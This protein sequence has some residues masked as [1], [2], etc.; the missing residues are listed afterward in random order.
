MSTR[1]KD[2]DNRLRGKRVCIVG[3]AMSP[4]DYTE[5][6]FHYD[7]VVL[8][9]WAIKS[10]S[11]ICSNREKANFPLTFFSYHYGTPFHRDQFPE[12]LMANMTLAL[13]EHDKP[14]VPAEKLELG[15]YMQFTACNILP[16]MLYR[17]LLTTNSH[18]RNRSMLNESNCLYSS[19][20]TT[21]LALHYLYH[22]G[23]LEV[24]AVGMHDV[25]G[26]QAQTYDTRL[27]ATNAPVPAS[28]Y[29]QAQSDFSLATGMK[30]Y[31]IEKA[32]VRTDL[33]A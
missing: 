30:I 13:Q 17:Q 33:M 21:L 10:A 19:S 16:Y 4:V 22:A 6:F 26:V 15:Q 12:M 32:G 3:G 28:I 29:L 24:D 1:L 31:Y 2:H 7:E 5:L 11:S 18:L 25:N 9:N 14:Y 23:V 8:V 20:N 27:Q